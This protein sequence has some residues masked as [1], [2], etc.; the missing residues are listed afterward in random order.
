MNRNTC[1]ILK[2]IH[3]QEES[4]EESAPAYGKLSVPRNPCRI[5]SPSRDVLIVFSSP[6]LS[7]SLF[8]VF[9]L[10]L[11]RFFLSIFH[12][13]LNRVSNLKQSPPLIPLTPSVCSNKTRM[14]YVYVCVVLPL[15]QPVGETSKMLEWF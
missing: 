12:S 8:K 10:L 6:T 15:F 1:R 14:L 4:L 3:P 5:P 13:L 2:F 7:L 9:A 11:F